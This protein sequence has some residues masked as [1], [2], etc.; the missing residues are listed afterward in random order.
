MQTI[1]PR[2]AVQA[3]P[4]HPTPASGNPD[5]PPED[6]LNAQGNAESLRSVSEFI[7]SQLPSHPPATSTQQFL[8]SSNISPKR[9]GV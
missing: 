9:M 7:E 2:N 8:W 5:L 6:R 1:D 4:N 3:V